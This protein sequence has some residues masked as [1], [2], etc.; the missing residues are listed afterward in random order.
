MEMDPDRKDGF[1]SLKLSELLE[2]KSFLSQLCV[3]LFNQVIYDK[4]MTI[5]EIGTKV[6]NFRTI[7]IHGVDEY[8]IQ[9]I[10]LGH[11]S[12]ILDIVKI[13]KVDKN[14]DEHRD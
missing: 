6:P 10:Q 7:K 1:F 14:L 5:G 8:L 12:E 2:I 11:L 3:L 4:N 9:N 13:K